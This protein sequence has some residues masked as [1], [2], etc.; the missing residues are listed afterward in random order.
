MVL[1]MDMFNSLGVRN[2][3]ELEVV[4]VVDLLF[5]RL[6][7]GASGFLDMADFQELSSNYTAC[8]EIVHTIR[9]GVSVSP[10]LS[11]TYSIHDRE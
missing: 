9:S 8:E 3:S 4:A 5:A 2:P 7:L 11:P 1:V 10:T 6:D